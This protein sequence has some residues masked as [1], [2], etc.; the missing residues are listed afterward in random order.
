MQDITGRLRRTPRLHALLPR[1]LDNALALTAAD[2][3]NVQL[4]DPASGALLLVTQAG[5]GPAFT[6]YFAVVDDKHSACGRAAVERDQAVI[7]DVMTDPGFAPHREMAAAA[8]FR[9]VQSTPLA[10]AGGQ[11]VGMVSTHWRRPGRPADR[12]LRMLKLFGALAGEAV[13]RHLRPASGYPAGTGEDAL[14]GP[15]TGL[16][17]P[18]TALGVLAGQ[19]VR[20]LSTVGLSLAKAQAVRGA[21]SADGQIAAV[22]GDLDQTIRDIG[23][24]A[25]H[26][27]SRGQLSDR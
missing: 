26:A 14:G 17:P 3:G 2:F 7:A 10:I 11:V 1:V 27:S 8:G 13:A 24:L 20:R 16:F 5:F 12:D 22:I 18:G 4:L 6:R 9:A 15:H 21:D 19:A 23:L 25:F